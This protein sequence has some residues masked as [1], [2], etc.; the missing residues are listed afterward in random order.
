M[1]AEKLRDCNINVTRI[2]SREA[3]G[4]HGVPEEKVVSRYR[5]ALLLIPFLVKVCDIMHIYDNTEEPF[6]I[7]KKR[8]TELFFWENAYWTEEKIRSLVF[9]QP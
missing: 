1:S 7:F 3:R 9:E 2:K 6:R 5:K 8:K 4:G